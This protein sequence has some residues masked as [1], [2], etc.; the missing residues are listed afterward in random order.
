MS[1]ERSVTHVSERTKALSQSQRLFPGPL[2]VRIR[3]ISK[4][5]VPQLNDGQRLRADRIFFSPPTLVA[6]D[7][8]G[9]AR[10]LLLWYALWGVWILNDPPTRVPRGAVPSRQMSHPGANPPN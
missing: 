9:L 1:P 2:L 4:N 5:A 3:G 7:S 6:S 8:G 10:T